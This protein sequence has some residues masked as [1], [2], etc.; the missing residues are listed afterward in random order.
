MQEEM[1]AFVDFVQKEL[2]KRSEKD[3]EDIQNALMRVAPPQIIRSRGG[4]K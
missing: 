2:L 1:Q 3:R 4:S